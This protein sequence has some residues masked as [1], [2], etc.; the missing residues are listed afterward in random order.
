MKND[1]LSAKATRRVLELSQMVGTTEKDEKEIDFFC[2]PM[3]SI[4]CLIS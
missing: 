1:S 2:T 3:N 4:I